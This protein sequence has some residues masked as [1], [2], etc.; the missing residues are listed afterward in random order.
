MNVHSFK[1][2]P[3]YS[4]YEPRHQ[5]LALLPM[6]HP[7]LDPSGSLSMTVMMKATKKRE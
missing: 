1:G 5:L 2:L 6:V 4:Q 7:P 3:L